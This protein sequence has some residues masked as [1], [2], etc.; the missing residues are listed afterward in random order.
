MPYHFKQVGEY[1]VHDIGPDG[2]I[3]PPSS[4]SLRGIKQWRED[5]G[6]FS[7]VPKDAMADEVFAPGASFAL[8]VGKKAAGRL[9]DGVEHNGFPS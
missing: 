2:E 9:L 5:L 4:M 1:S 7:D 3:E 8:P 6:R